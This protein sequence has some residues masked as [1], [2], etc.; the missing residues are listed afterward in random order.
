ML[1]F[2]FL[3]MIASVLWG[4]IPLSISVWMEIFIPRYSW[5]YL[6]GNTTVFYIDVMV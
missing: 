6:D 1:N 5:S 2:V 3:L 4:Y